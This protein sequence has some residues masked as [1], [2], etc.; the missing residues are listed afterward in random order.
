MK[1]NIVLRC[2]VTG[3]PTPNVTWYRWNTPV[4]S[5]FVLSDG[6]LALNITIGGGSDASEEGVLYHCQATN[7]LNNFTA[8]IRSRDVTV[9]Y[10]C[11]W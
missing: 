9:T 7:M 5:G 8:T 1:A 10:R 6:T 2:R 11:E 3:D 4:D